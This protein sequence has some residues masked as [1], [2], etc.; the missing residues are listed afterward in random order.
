MKICLPDMTIE[1][2]IWIGNCVVSIYCCS[3]RTYRFS[4]VNVTGETFTC[5][6]NFPNFDSAEFMAK[7]KAKKLAVYRDRF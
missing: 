4:I 3:D 1:T 6:S 7:R 5:S 2:L